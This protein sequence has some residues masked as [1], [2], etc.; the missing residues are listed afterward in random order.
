MNVSASSKR[1]LFVITLSEWGGAQKYVYDLAVAAQ[2]RGDVV[3][4]IVGGTGELMQQLQSAGIDTI[5]F[6]LMKRGIHTVNEFRVL[7][8]LIREVKAFKP[9]VV[10]GNSSKA[11]LLAAI[12][13]RVSGVHHILY[14]CHGWAFNE[15]GN[16]FK[17]ILYWI[18]H[19]L[20]VLVND[21]TICV[22]E[23][24]KRDAY[25]MPFMRSKLITIHLG[26]QPTELLP[27]EAAR[28]E[29]VPI[30]PANATWIGTVGRLD[31]V[32][33][34]DVLIRAF[35]VVHDS[36]PAAILV[37]VG[38]GSKRSELEGLI[39]NLSLTDAVF[40][41]GHKENAL[42]YMQ[43]FDIFAFPSYSESFGFAVAEAGLAALPVVASNVG[44]IPEIITDGEQGLLV[45]RANVEA[46][47]GALIKLISEPALRTQFGNKLKEKILRDFTKERM[48]EKT[49]ALYR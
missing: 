45:K 28:A 20:T 32:K 48:I 2:A 34:H 19:Y 41:C 33:L 36:F 11:G 10:H 43:A 5:S 18:F 4:V 3:R 9:D 6:D 40:L 22:S 17:K 42:R 37:I 25:S 31:P 38:E 8:R 26:V 46:L 35:K 30:V 44:G 24:I 7:T 13:G 12:A 49:F 15:T 1:V 23:A 14:T 39:K 21:T 47:S 27:K 16:V 29:L